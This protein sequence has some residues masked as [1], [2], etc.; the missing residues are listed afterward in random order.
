MEKSGSKGACFARGSIFLGPVEI[1]W[2]SQCWSS[3][4]RSK[5][6]FLVSLLCLLWFSTLPMFFLFVLVALT[7]FNALSTL[8]AIML[9]LPFPHW[10]F[11]FSCSLCLS[12]NHCHCFFWLLTFTIFLFLL[13]LSCLLLLI[14]LL[15]LHPLP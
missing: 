8:V 10:A 2:T 5:C 15:S 9:S 12:D 6:S 11:C 7:I 4:N 14:D 1:S 13:Q 3:L